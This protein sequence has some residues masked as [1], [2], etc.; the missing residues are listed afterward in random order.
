MSAI[1]IGCGASRITPELG[2]SM[3][4]YFTERKATAIHDDLYAK[5]MIFDDGNVSAGLLCCDLIC[6]H[7]DEVAKIR[8]IISDKTG[9]KGENVMICA[10]HTHTGPRTR[11]FRMSEDDEVTL[12]WLEGLPERAA[13]AAVSAMD[14]LE[15]CDIAGGISYEDRIAFNRRYR[16]KD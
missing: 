4:G 5:A 11:T 10:T 16:M 14:N 7:K 9:V 13:Q 12:Q 8:K 1:K 2:V 15:L 3:A 6:L